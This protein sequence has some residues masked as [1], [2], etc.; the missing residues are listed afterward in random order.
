MDTILAPTP[1]D[2]QSWPDEDARLRAAA[3]LDGP[4]M[5]RTVPAS[6]PEVV[7]VCDEDLLT[8][9]LGE[10][11]DAA[12]MGLIITPLDELAVRRVRRR[13]R[14]LVQNAAAAVILP[15]TPGQVT[16]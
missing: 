6:T 7:A 13:Q 5:T 12:A 4:C 14:H 2:R 10:A 3:A 16:A 15:F 9:A 1:P 11:L 8:D